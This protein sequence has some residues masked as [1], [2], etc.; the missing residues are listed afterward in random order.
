MKYWE[1]LELLGKVSFSKVEFTIVA[2]EDSGC[3]FEAHTMQEVFDILRDN[4]DFTR[5]DK[6]TIERVYFGY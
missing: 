2:F 6:H 5:T 3:V 4:I 1:F